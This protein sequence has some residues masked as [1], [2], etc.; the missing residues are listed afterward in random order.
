MQ[1]VLLQNQEPD[2]LLHINAVLIHTL[3]A[4]VG[5]HAPTSGRSRNYKRLGIQYSKTC[6]L[7]E[8]GNVY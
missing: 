1:I 6:P 3:L 8:S 7:E 5:V 2:H 4:Q